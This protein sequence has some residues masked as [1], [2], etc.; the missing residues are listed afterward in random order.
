MKVIGMN[1]KYRVIEMFLTGYTLDEIVEQL[2]VSKGSVVSIVSD[3]REGRLRL[4]DRMTAYVD[5]LR[6][7]V[8]DMKKKGV[9][10]TQLKSYERLHSKLQEMGANNEEA[11]GWLDTSRDIASSTDSDDQFIRMISDLVKLSL[12][13]GMN[14][15]DMIKDY[16]EKLTTLPELNREIQQ[17]KEGFNKIKAKYEKQKVKA[18]KGIDSLIREIAVLQNR[19]RKQK[20][21]LQDQLDE[22]MAQNRLSWEKVNT[23]LAVLNAKLHKAGLWEKDIDKISK[24]IS[25]AGTL[26]A[27]IRNKQS[28]NEE[29]GKEEKTRISRLNDLKREEKN[30]ELSIRKNRIA[31]GFLDEEV[32]EKRNKVTEIEKVIDDYVEDL[33]ASRLIMEFLS[34]PYRLTSKEFGKLRDLMTSLTVRK[35]SLETYIERV[36]DQIRYEPIQNRVFRR[37]DRFGKIRERAR[38]QL[39]Y[40]LLPL[41][42]DKVIFISGYAGSPIGRQLYSLR[43]RF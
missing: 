6:R 1:T 30:L 28:K 21:D 19:Y 8:V 10:L 33:T 38:E 7:L 3:F 15:K 39:A 20:R 27:H 5:E 31:V 37:L 23:V 29:I 25:T 9:S 24:E 12:N 17:K 43:G 41:F 18:K 40:H 26:E 4:P 42:K 32:E 35:I 22:Y 36:G 13:T 16:H 34:S 2:P 14:V 11:E